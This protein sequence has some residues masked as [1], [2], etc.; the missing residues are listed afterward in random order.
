MTKTQEKEM[1]S[2][3]ATHCVGSWANYL[4]SVNLSFHIYKES[5][6][7]VSISWVCYSNYLGQCIIEFSA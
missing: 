2:T 3:C 7:I 6:I 5:T 4:T 1:E